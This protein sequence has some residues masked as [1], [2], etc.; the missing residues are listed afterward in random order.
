MG[1]GAPGT[2][3]DV[4]ETESVELDNPTPYLPEYI[5][6]LH[7]SGGEHHM[8]EAERCGWI[9]ELA[10]VGLDADGGRSADYRKLAEQKLGVVVRLDHGYAPLGTLPA[11]FQYQAFAQS[12]GEFVARSRGCHI[13]IIGNEPNHATEWP[14]GQPIYPWHYA[15][16]YKLCRAAIRR[17][18]G[19]AHDL[20]LVA[21]PAPWNAQLTYPTNPSGDWIQYFYDVM[22]D[23]A[24][25]ECDGFSLH[26]YTRAHDPAMIAADV[27]QQQPG[28]QHLR[29]EFRTYRD[30]MAAIPFR[31]RHLPVIITET[32][33]TDPARGW[34]PADNLGWVQTA[35]AEIATWNA[36]P[37]NQPILGLL[38]F[39]WPEAIHHGHD[40]WSIADRPS[41]IEDFKTALAHPDSAR[42]RLRPPSK[43]EPVAPYEM[44]PESKRW[45]GR[46]IAPAGLRLRLGPSTEYAEI[47]TLEFEALV[48]VLAES[49][50]W[51]FVQANGRQGYVARPWT[52]WYTSSRPLIVEGE[53]AL[54]ADMQ[55]N[56]SP[57]APLVQRRV[58][59]TWN[60][61]GAFILEQSKE[62]GIEAGIVLAV[63]MAESQ[64][65]PFA[66]DGRM[67]IRFEPHIF[68]LYWGRNNRERFGDHF[69]YNPDLPW[70]A[71]NQ[72]EWRPTPNDEWR[73]VHQNQAGEW[74]VFE[75]A[76]SLD[77][78]AA[79]RSIS[80]GAP[81]IMGFN[82]EG[83]GYPTVQ[84]MFHAFSTNARAQ[85]ESFFRYMVRRGIV[86]AV[87]RRDFEAF[88]R[89][90]NGAGQEA[91]Y[92]ERMR[93]W[94]DAFNAVVG[95]GAEA[96]PAAVPAT[97]ATPLPGSL[98]I[99]PSP[100]TSRPLSEIDPTLYQA[101]RDHVM[102][103][104]ANNQVMFDR[105]LKG[106]MNPY[107]TTVTVYAI[108]CS[109]GVTSFVVA[110]IL[111]LRAATVG[112]ALGTVAIFGGLSIASFLTYFVSR[113]L[114]ALEE[115]LQFITWLG[116]VYNTYWTRLVHAMDQT[117]FH[118]EI[119]DATNDAVASIQDMLATHS[120]HT[121]KR[122]SPQS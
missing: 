118:Q 102:A 77:E 1:P 121:S 87:R 63:L 44:L 14:Q 120:E 23:L 57:N 110:V 108:L 79:M 52:A 68:Y 25:D 32:D 16:A 22:K 113:P 34:E 54:P 89:S 38:L 119:E 41:I 73:P 43:L 6:G 40:Q 2:D 17:Q 42:F 27:W 75:L 47:D 96:L 56:I 9:L 8:V 78:T 13:W 48:E 19:H 61:Y 83:I 18:P 11:P 30:F 28:Y 98:P 24:D 45:I 92:A 49:G 60:K 51:L 10:A 21:G 46:V 93:I 65:E 109:I 86:E 91:I 115:N 76:R 100:D 81:Q 53:L 85:F 99:P 69:R 105:I 97:G 55:V 71:P 26:T 15:K 114:Q 12:C 29:D 62:L 70:N 4:S 104:Y 107:W 36:T 7:E 90:Y 122:P 64:G 72:Q 80:M 39:R 88:A 82:H 84:E 94:L 101:W 66:G 50:D 33:P 58:A 31:L 95:A 20:V 106:F 5:F 3:A 117:T 37:Q 67:I 116:I 103:G 59:E 112:A 111:G 74:E 35:Y